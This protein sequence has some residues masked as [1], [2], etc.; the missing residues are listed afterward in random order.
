MINLIL[1]KS[2]FLEFLKHLPLFLCNFSWFQIWTSAEFMEYGEHSDTW[3]AQDQKNQLHDKSHFEKKWLFDFIKHLPLF[4][5]SR[6]FVRILNFYKMMTFREHRVT[7][8]SKHQEIRLHDKLILRKN[9][10]SDSRIYRYFWATA[11]TL[12]KLRMCFLNKT[13]TF[14]NHT[15]ENSVWC[16]SWFQSQALAVTF[17]RACACVCLCV[18]VRICVSVCVSR[19]H[20][21]SSVHKCFWR[22]SPLVPS[23]SCLPPFSSPAPFL[24]PRAR[25]S[26]VC[27]D[28]LNARVL[29]Q[30]TRCWIP[31]LHVKSSP[32]RDTQQRRGQRCSAVLV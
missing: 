15:P 31:A 26:H 13:K 7:W 32:A 24:R 18:S 12:Q 8:K 14:G 10:F 22:F 9:F 16:I 29:V 20:Y 19:F 4:Q 25:L 27:R 2:H 28:S 30:D 23:Y 21:H 17:R 1:R 3:K 11:R 5:Y 6:S